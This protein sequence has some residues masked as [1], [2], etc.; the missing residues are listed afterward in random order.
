MAHAATTGEMAHAATTGDSC[1][2]FAGGIDGSA[3]AAIGSFIV[4]GEFEW[5]GDKYKLLDVQA[6]R[7]DGKQIKPGVFYALKGGKPVELPQ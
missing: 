2:A 4:I 7:V 6:L 3:A 1:I 5:M